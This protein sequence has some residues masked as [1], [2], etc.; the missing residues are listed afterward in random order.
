MQYSRGAFGSLV[1]MEKEKDPQSGASSVI[2]RVL[3]WSVLKKKLSE[4]MC[5]LKSSSSL[6]IEKSSGE[7]ASGPGP[8]P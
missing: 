4:N 5:L 7:V 8:G 6:C 3:L 1:L 2:K